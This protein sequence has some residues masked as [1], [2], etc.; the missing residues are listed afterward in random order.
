KYGIQAYAGAPLLDEGKPL[1]VLYVFDAAPRAFNAEDLGFLRSLAR[2]A[3][4]G[5]TKVNSYLQLQRTNETLERHR[6]ELEEKNRQLTTAKETA[7]AA[8]RAKS[9]FLATISHEIRT[10]MNA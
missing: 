1:R 4:T 3:A 10:P 2:R 6:A 5:I 7:E 9:E 8:S